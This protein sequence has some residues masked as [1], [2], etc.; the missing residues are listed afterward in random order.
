MDNGQGD[1]KYNVHSGHLTA[2][3]GVLALGC[4]IAIAA[5]TSDDE[6]NNDDDDY[7]HMMDIMNMI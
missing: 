7:D 1:Y 4:W 6:N 2:P 3:L 5:T